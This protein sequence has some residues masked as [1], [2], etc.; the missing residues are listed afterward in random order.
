MPIH[1]QFSGGDFHP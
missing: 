1:K